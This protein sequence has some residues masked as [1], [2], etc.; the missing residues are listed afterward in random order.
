VNGA[1][2][3]H[4]IFVVGDG[5]GLLAAAVAADPDVALVVD[6]DAVVGAG[7]GVTGARAAP[8]ADEI[9]LG[10]EFKNR[11][12]WSAA[13]RGPGRPGGVFLFLFERTLAMKDPN[14]VASIDGYADRSAD[15]PMVG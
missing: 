2:V 15:D 1:S 3:G 12:G 6:I 14:V 8:G 13:L 5:G 11:W 10:I 7:P 4:A 9:A